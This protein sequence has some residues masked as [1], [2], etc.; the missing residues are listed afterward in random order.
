VETDLYPHMPTYVHTPH[1]IPRTA[2]LKR[3]VCGGP[4]HSKFY[5]PVARRFV[6]FW[7]FGR[8]KF[9]TMGDSLPR[10]PTNHRA[11]F[12]AAS[13]ILVGQIRNRNNTHTSKH[14]RTVNDISTFC[15]WVCVN[16]KYVRLR[17]RP[18]IHICRSDAWPAHWTNRPAHGPRVFTY[19]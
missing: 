9:P 6:R 16:N 5:F 19:I 18:Y 15:L 4:S 10:T 11:K 3:D 14:T 8:A 17:V 7:A 2:H 1:H 12:D 13:F